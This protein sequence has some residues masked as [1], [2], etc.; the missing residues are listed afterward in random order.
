MMPGIACFNS[1]DLDENIIVGS[2]NMKALYP[3][4]GIEFTILVVCDFLKNSD[5]V[6][7]V[8][9]Y[10]EMGLYISLNRTV[11]QI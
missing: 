8:V 5:I 10:E 1:E 11:K 6:I 2:T 3:S 7:H 4:L 9:N